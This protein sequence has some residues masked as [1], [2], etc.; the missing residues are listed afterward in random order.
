MGSRNQKGWP[1]FPP[2]D[3]EPQT[4]SRGDPTAKWKTTIR[5]LLSSGGWER[6]QARSILMFGLRGKRPPYNMGAVPICSRGRPSRMVCL[7]LWV[8]VRSAALEQHQS[9][10]GID[11]Q[12]PKLFDLTSQTGDTMISSNPGNPFKSLSTLKLLPTSWWKLLMSPSC[13]AM[14]RMA[15]MRA[16][17]A[18][19]RPQPF[20]TQQ[21]NDG[22]QSDISHC[23]SLL[24][25][26]PPTLSKQG[27]ALAIVVACRP[28]SP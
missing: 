15:V 1:R 8:D 12:R 22:R 7:H 25:D 4:P 18:F 20:R 17:E 27:F 14:M 23:D 3:G 6:K 2:C 21:G 16:T 11:G 19:W 24:S 26:C 28:S 5:F 9:E 13:D 10:T